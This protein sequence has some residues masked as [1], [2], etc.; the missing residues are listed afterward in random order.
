ML[1]ITPCESDFGDCDELF[2]CPRCDQVLYCSGY[3][4]QFVL[5]LPFMQK[6]CLSY[7]Y[8]RS[9]IGLSPNNADRRVC[10]FRGEFHFPPTMQS[11]RPTYPT[12]TD[13]VKPTKTTT[14][15]SITEKRLST[16]MTTDSPKM[17]STNASTS[18]NP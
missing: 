8:E 3:D 6:Y 9:L 14:F 17:F 12:S 10:Q 1:R 15:S 7:D 16:Q 18:G 5:G 13:S 11:I 4:V 2:N